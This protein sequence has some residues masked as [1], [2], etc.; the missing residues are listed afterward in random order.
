[1]ST[2]MDRFRALFTSPKVVQ[3]YEPLVDEDDDNV[4]GTTAAPPG[5]TPER[6]FSLVE[7]A[8]FLLLGITMLWA[9]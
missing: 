2:T 5:P 7:Y 1:M 6:L 9:W 4:R 3:D 8:V